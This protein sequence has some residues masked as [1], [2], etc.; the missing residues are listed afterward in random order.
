[1]ASNWTDEMIMRHKTVI[2]IN[3]EKILL[4]IY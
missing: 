2:E 3:K 4:D 1:M